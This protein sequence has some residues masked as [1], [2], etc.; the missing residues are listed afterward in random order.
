[1]ERT[2]AELVWERANGR[3]EYCQMPQEYDG[4]V[5]EIDHVIAKKHQGPT[6]APN[7]ALACFPYNSYKGSDIAGRDPKTRR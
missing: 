5:H 4:F 7:L 1:M 3:C 6:A 2:L